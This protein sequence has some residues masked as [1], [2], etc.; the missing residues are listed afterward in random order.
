MTLD[1]FTHAIRV[2]PRWL[3]CGTCVLMAVAVVGMVVS[4]LY[5][6]EIHPKYPNTTFSSVSSMCNITGQSGVQPIEPYVHY[7]QYTFYVTITTSN[8]T[9]LTYTCNTQLYCVSEVHHQEGVF[10]PNCIDVN[11]TKGA[12]CT[13]AS[14]DQLSELSE[15]IGT[16]INIGW[17]S[18]FW[19]SL[20]ILLS[21]SCA[22][23][24]G[25]CLI[26]PSR[27]NEPFVNTEHYSYT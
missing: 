12:K 17:W 23:L 3:F 19:I 7:Y 15:C 20:A 11:G 18:V 5:F 25:I 22:V 14:Q 8:H 2:M 16:Y 26:K 4:P 10:I 21:M 1:G 27:E 9:S 13:K 24:G 6:Y